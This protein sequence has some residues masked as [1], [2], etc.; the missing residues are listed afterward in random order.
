MHSI[1]RRLALYALGALVLVTAACGDDDDPSAPTNV[2]G[3]YTLTTVNGHA[4]PTTV[5][6]GDDPGFQYKFEVL[7]GE[8]QLDA[9]GTFQD[10]TE[11]RET[12][13]NGTP[14][15]SDQILTGTWTRTGNTLTLTDEDDDSYTLT[16][17]ND[18][19]LVQTDDLG[20][21]QLTARY[22]KQ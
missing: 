10:F 5:Y 3:T 1:S 20:G 22:V 7:A 21:V 17:Q 13:D 15:T 6:E 8:L 18:G 14:E 11:I 19:S 2:A 9:D 4:L 16:V 12:I